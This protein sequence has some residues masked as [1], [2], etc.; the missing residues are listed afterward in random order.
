MTNKSGRLPL[1]TACSNQAPLD[2]VQYLVQEY[3]EFL[4]MND[5][6]GALPLRDA[7]SS[8][9]EL[10]DIRY[11]VQEY[12]ECLHVTNS[13]GEIPFAW[14]RDMGRQKK[15]SQSC[16]LRLESTVASGVAVEPL[17]S[18]QP[19]V[20]PGKSPFSPDKETFVHPKDIDS[21]VSAQQ[22]SRSLHPVVLP[23]PHSHPTATRKS[24]SRNEPN[25]RYRGC[26]FYS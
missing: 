5:N 3:P 2:I 12:P 24:C 19:S 1:H 26:V 21:P 14:P 25:L 22:P 15:T 23:S 13:N 8:Q 17:S 16:R 20:Q 11:L 18:P 6:N 10:Y 4:Q 9:V 7:C